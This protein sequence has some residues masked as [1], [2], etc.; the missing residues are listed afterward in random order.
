MTNLLSGIG[1]SVVDCGNIEHN[2]LAHPDNDKAMDRR[3][4]SE[5]QVKRHGRRARC[6]DRMICA[7]LYIDPIAV[8]KFTI[9]VPKSVIPRHCW[10][11]WD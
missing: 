6:Q 1:Y 5:E 4:H 2:V 3:R 7:L 10:P 8:V 9:T 11:F